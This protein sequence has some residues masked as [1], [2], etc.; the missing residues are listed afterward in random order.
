ML[1]TKK[2][3]LKDVRLNGSAYTLEPVAMK[4]KVPARA[5]VL[6]LRAINIHCNGNENEYFPKEITV[7]DVNRCNSSGARSLITEDLVETDKD[8]F[9]LEEDDV[10]EITKFA[11]DMFVKAAKIQ[12]KIQRK[13]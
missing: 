4:L 10:L 11:Y 9:N 2:L 8:M 7:A 1:F 6:L 13:K 3:N 5:A 12:R